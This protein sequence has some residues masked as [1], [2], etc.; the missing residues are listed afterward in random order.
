MLLFSSGSLFIGGTQILGYANG[1]STTTNNSSSCPSNSVLNLV[2]GGGAPNTFN[3]LN[4]H[5]PTAA[6]ISHLMF[7]PVSPMFAQSGAPYPQ[8]TFVSSITTNSQY[9]VWGFHIRPGAKWSNGDSITS[10]DFVNTYSSKYA[11]NA[12]YDF[13]NLRSEIASTSTPN[14]ST[15]VFN[16]NA[17]DAHFNDKLE[18]LTSVV[19]QQWVSQGPNFNGFGV[20]DV[21][22]G[23]FYAVNYTAGQTQLLLLRNPYFVPEPK[24]CEILVSFVETD[25]S[26]PTLLISGAYDAGTI[27]QSAAVSILAHPNLHVAVPQTL[28]TD[29]ITYNTSIYPYNNAAF[30]QA[31]AYGINQS[32]IVQQA[33][34]GYG[35]TAYS[36]QGG[37]P[38]ASTQWYNPNQTEYSFNTTKALTLLESMGIKMG[39]DNHLQYPN[40]TDVTL[41]IW[42]AND[43]A[44]NVLAANIVQQNLQHLGFVV[45]VHASAKGAMIGDSYR[46]VQGIDSAML[47]EVTFAAFFGNPYTDALPSWDVY[48]NFAP[49]PTWEP[50]TQAQAAYQ[51][52]LS[53]LEATS[54]PSQEYK[55]LANIQALNAENLPLI[56]LCYGEQLIG[57]STQRFT[58]WS[59]D[60]LYSNGAQWNYTA[61]AQL[62]PVGS[63]TGTTSVASSTSSIS[64]T[65]STSSTI[66]SSSSSSNASSL[67][68][69]ISYLAVIGVIVLVGI[70]LAVLGANY[71]KRIP[72]FAQ[73]HQ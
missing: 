42:A 61:L 48:T 33:F 16:L 55:Y 25:S 60:L 34:A 19:P 28:L 59:N 58:G 22:D 73:R 4:V 52:N 23:P 15:V 63:S 13:E 7:E 1:A 62:T 70:S 38:T 21:T 47:M 18:F 14:S 51:G 3:F 44:G 12:T 57:Y 64:S 9:T 56:M 20:T 66:Q 71:R 65:G 31:L 29:T 36:S 53:A 45:N 10:Q 17:P 39:S 24:I 68:F 32:Q 43:Y 46:N 50:T 8:G 72:A 35:V 41:T 27:D 54:N 37:V 2:L 49:E 67:A 11:L 69:P 5:G 6:L 30:R 26:T 40:G